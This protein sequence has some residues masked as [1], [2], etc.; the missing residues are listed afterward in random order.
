MALPYRLTGTEPWAIILWIIALDRDKNAAASSTVAN[1]S[2]LVR[3]A[4]SGDTLILHV[5]TP[6]MG[7]GKEKLWWMT[8]YIR[9][10]GIGM[11][12]T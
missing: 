2:R 12:D 4:S 9:E 6:P 7:T 11:T 3:T 1:P 5:Y 10:T 8:L